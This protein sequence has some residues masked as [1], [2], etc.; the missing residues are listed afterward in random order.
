MCQ[1]IKRLLKGN[2]GSINENVPGGTVHSSAVKCS[3][4]NTIYSAIRSAHIILL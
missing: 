2:I 1:K 4:W 3:N